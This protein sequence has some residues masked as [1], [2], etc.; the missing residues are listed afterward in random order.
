MTLL[1]S[2][3]PPELQTKCK[4]E[5]TKDAL[6]NTSKCVEEI[7]K[8][9]V[10]RSC[11]MKANTMAGL[12]KC[13]KQA[14]AKGTGSG[15]RNARRAKTAEAI[16]ELDKMYK[17]A[18]VYYSSPRIS[19]EGNK[20]PCQFPASTPITPPPGPN[21]E[22]PCCSSTY[23]TDGDHRCDSNPDHWTTPTWSALNF[24]IY[25]QHYYVY[26]YD[27]NG[28]LSDAKM[29]ATAYGDLDCDGVWSTFQKLS[30]GDPEASRAECAIQAAPAFYVE[31]ET[32]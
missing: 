26:E 11:I 22:H 29:T 16:D 30:F 9:G 1:C 17:G 21:G 8:I 24:G 15:G 14:T 5:M 18:A 25:D 20:L 13:E 6:K 23:D 32:E 3:A 7:K 2:E 28:E 27:S 10:S 12:Q 31:K 4:E 19:R